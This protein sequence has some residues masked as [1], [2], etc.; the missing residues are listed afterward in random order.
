MFNIL[1]KYLPNVVAQGW[2]GDAGWQTAILQTLY[3]T[4]WSA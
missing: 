3:M 4:F 2:S 1:E